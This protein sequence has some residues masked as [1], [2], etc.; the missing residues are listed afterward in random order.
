MNIDFI[1]LINNIGYRMNICFTHVS[2]LRGI[3]FMFVCYRNA[4]LYHASTVHTASDPA[5]HKV[6]LSLE[7]T[8]DH[9]AGRLQAAVRGDCDKHLVRVRDHRHRHA[10]T[11]LC[12]QQGVHTLEGTAA[13]QHRGRRAHH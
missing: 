9:V 10:E 13:H 11:R 1:N 5:I 6:Y 8:E 7:L 2:V 3:S 4:M 12:R